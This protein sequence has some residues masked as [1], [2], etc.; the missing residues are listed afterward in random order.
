MLDNTDLYKAFIDRKLDKFIEALEVYQADP[1]Y[2]VAEVELTIFEVILRTPNSAT[3]IQ[4]CLEYGADFLVQNNKHKYPLHHVIESKCIENLEAVE[5]SLW[6]IE[7]TAGYKLKIASSVN[8]KNSENQNSLHLLIDYLTNENVDEIFKMIKILVS[9]GCNPNSPDNSQNS[10]FYL[11]IKKLNE[12]Q[13]G[14]EILDF[15]VKNSEIDFF[16]HKS[17]EIIEMMKDK[18]LID[19]PQDEPFSFIH[20]AMLNLLEIGNINKFETK[21]TFCDFHNDLDNLSKYLEVA[22][23]KSLINIVDLLIANGIDVNRISKESQQ[24]IPPIFLAYKNADLGV[25]KS[26]LL[27]KPITRVSL[28]HEKIKYSR[29]LLH[30]F[31]YD[32]DS[33]QKK[34]ELTVDQKKCFDLLLNDPRCNRNYLNTLGKYGNPAIYYSVGYGIDYMTMKLLEKGAFIGPVITKIRKSLFKDFLDSCITSNNEFHDNKDFKVSINYK[35]LMPTSDVDNKLRRR[36]SV[37]NQKL[38]NNNYLSK[39][40]LNNVEQGLLEAYPSEKTSNK[41]SPEMSPLK[42]LTKN[43]HYKHLIMHPVIS[44]FVCLKWKKIRFSL[45]LN[46]LL[47]LFFILT[48]IPFIVIHRK[49]PKSEHY[50][51][52]NHLLLFIFSCISLFML[53][54]REIMQFLQSPMRYFKFLSNYIDITLITSSTCVLLELVSNRD[55]LRILHTIIILLSTWECFNLLGFLPLVSISLHIKMFKKV[56]MTFLQSLAIYSV[57]I[58][59]FALSFHTL[60]GDRFWMDLQVCGDKNFTDDMIEIPTNTSRSDRFNNFYT[61]RSSIIKSFVM[62][63]GELDA[64]DIYLESFT[65][66]GVFMLFLFVVTIVLYNLLNALAISDTQE[67]VCDAK[68]IDL[69]ERILTMYQHELNIFNGSSAQSE[70]FQKIISLFPDTIPDGIIILK[71]NLSRNVLKSN[72]E[73]ITN[74]FLPNI[75]KYLGLEMTVSRDILQDMCNL[76]IKKR[77]THAEDNVRYFM[78]FIHHNMIKMN[79]QIGDLKKM[80]AGVTE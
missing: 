76:L 66:I 38:D 50:K 32:F 59:G 74:D 22:V 54:I 24:K 69:N 10:P 60:H 80:Q 62:L 19:I 70:T 72:E 79:E 65:Y 35:F 71:P 43:D 28:Y 36:Y 68:L 75:L 41:Y 51:L 42:M 13:N 26:F 46:L 18:Y 64:S 78:K 48:F 29:T 33:K 56:F 58:L 31:F 27:A 7:S 25:F 63:T 11:F 52:P 23:S 1:N 67:I 5:K 16:T 40:C 53:A 21:F 9:Y 77:E 3:F 39:P 14:H 15:F 20:E 49:T 4:K 45:Y 12:L 2:H 57:I 47:T 73:S 17:T 8:V 30:N 6:N 44:S 34:I 37:F 55:L 61:L